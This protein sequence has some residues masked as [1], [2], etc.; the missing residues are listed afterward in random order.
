MLITDELG[1]VLMKNESKIAAAMVYGF[2]GAII[3]VVVISIFLFGT[4]ILTRETQTIIIEQHEP[5]AMFTE[6]WWREWITA[7][8]GWVAATVAGWVGWTQLRPL[9]R[10]GKQQVDRELLRALESEIELL[11]W[12]RTQSV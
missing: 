12:Y 9:V 11:D 5:I 7:F 3:G 10:Q 1:Q 4:G 6:D 8:S 2:V